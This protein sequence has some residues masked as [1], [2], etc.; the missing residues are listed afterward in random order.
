MQILFVHQNY[1]AQFGHVAHYLARR[2][3]HEC[4]FITEREGENDG[5]VRRILYKV[6]G[7][8][9]EHNHYCSRVFETTVW[10]SH[11]VYEA[12]RREPDVH[13]DLIVGHSGFGSTLFLK[14]LYDC[15]VLNYF[16]YY[17]HVKGSDLD[18][19]P[20]FPIRPP[21]RLRARI[22][23][24]MI[25][26]DL[27]N[28]SRGYSPTYWQKSQIPQE[29]QSKV[30]V[31]FDGV[32]TR[33]WRRQPVG[34]R[35]IGNWQVPRGCKL[36]T[37]A[38]RGMEGMRGFDIFMNV[39]HRLSRLRSDVVFAIAGQDRICYGGD[40]K[41][42][43]GKTLKQYLVEQGHLDLS[44]FH[45]LGLL[46][47]MDLARLFSLSDVHFYLTVPFILSWSVFD[48]LACGATLLASDTQP[49]REVIR[50]EQN[51]LLVDFYDED[52]FVD[53]ACKVL[54]DPGAYRP[55]GISGRTLVQERYSTDVC[56]PK[57]ARLYH[58]T[59]EERMRDEG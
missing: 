33:V 48:A 29:Y 39:A 26:L 38:T 3:G 40:A 22:R 21:D 4:L 19:R 25:L 34:D 14:E 15:P 42:T 45:F 41:H 9:T 58:A 23:N 8:A 10:R 2:H 11:A 46:K 30:D 12:L 55:L 56:L 57:L 6:K 49:V 35:R 52:G 24:A 1:P 54:D 16:E 59:A 47:P 7:G 5:P 18:F 31:C 13:P 50:H 20:E 51:G 36:V 43:E 32:D 17:Y 27:D 53:L 28:C 44:R 37:Y